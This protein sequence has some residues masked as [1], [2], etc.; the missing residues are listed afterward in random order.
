MNVCIYRRIDGR[1]NEW[2][3]KW[4]DGYIDER[5]GV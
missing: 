3:D 2:V 4:M 1:G 5:V